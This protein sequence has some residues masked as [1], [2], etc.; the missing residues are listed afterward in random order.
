VFKEAPKQ[1]TDVRNAA[2]DTD[3]KIKNAL[4]RAYNC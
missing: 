3:H 1:V 2:G 4:L